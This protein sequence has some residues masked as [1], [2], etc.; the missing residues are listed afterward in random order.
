MLLQE[1]LA[2]PD[3]LGRDL[4]Q[5]VLGRPDRAGG[6]RRG[7]RNG[8]GRVSGFIPDGQLC[9]GGRTQN[10]LYGSLDTV[11]AFAGPLLA[12]A[13]MLAWN[14]DFRAAASGNLPPL[15]KY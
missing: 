1:A 6:R 5:L 7:P 12:M 4:D 2:Q 14:D 11:G 13:L 9:S 10:G 15:M 8:A 3:R